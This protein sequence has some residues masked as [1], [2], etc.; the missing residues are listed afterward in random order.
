MSGTGGFGQSSSLSSSNSPN[1][2][3]F[4]SSSSAQTPRDVFEALFSSIPPKPA[5]YRYSE[6]FKDGNVKFR[7]SDGMIFSIHQK[8]LEVTAEG[9]PSSSVNGSTATANANEIIS[10]T[11]SSATLDLLFQFVYP[12]D[13]PDLSDLEFSALMDLAKAAEKYIVYNAI[14]V[15]QLRMRFVGAIY[16]SHL[17]V[18]TDHFDPLFRDFLSGHVQELF[19]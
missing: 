9:F 17:H 1:P 16:E 2:P 10:L 11:E 3:L 8:Y 4:Q 14:N 6:R 12:K 15:C 19:V 5:E 18:F 13:Q 7:S